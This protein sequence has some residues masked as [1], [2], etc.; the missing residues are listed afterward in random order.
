MRR[1]VQLSVE[2]PQRWLLRR[3][4]E[5][6]KVVC[7]AEMQWIQEHAMAISIVCCVVLLVAAVVLWLASEKPVKRVYMTEGFITEEFTAEGSP[8]GRK[9]SY[10]R[11][12]CPE[13][14]LYIRGYKEQILPSDQLSDR[15]RKDAEE[16]LAYYEKLFETMS[17]KDY[18]INIK[19]ALSGDKPKNHAEKA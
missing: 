14:E 15:S 10:K 5:A 19:Y 16:T 3:V 18:L 2:V 7:K 9:E 6:E 17:C 11:T 13:I 8:D 12:E 1:Q 4:K